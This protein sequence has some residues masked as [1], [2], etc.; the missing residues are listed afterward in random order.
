MAHPY[1]HALNS[2]KNFGGQYYDYLD[3]HSWL[4]ATK[5]LYANFRHR[6]LR[7]HQEGALACEE[8]FGKEII[9]SD[10]ERVSV[11]QI[12]LQH[13]EEDCEKVVSLSDWLIT[14]KCPRWFN[15]DSIPKRDDCYQ[16]LLKK[17]SAQENSFPQ[18]EAVV[19]FFYG[20]EI[21]HN[22]YWIAYRSHSYGIFEIESRLGEVLISSD[23]SRVI[24][25][26]Y[27]AEEVVRLQL[28]QRIPS[29]Q[30]WLSHLQAEPWMY[31][32]KKISHALV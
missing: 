29:V 14:M 30:D 3:I 24:P 6:A 5:A 17:V 16:R 1:H 11:R 13:I 26:R 4:D 12:A 10:R 32:T 15:H 28:V 7:H 20:T 22:P 8:L 31:R 23:A 2:S 9:N 21:D 25:T 19:D 18:L 27:A